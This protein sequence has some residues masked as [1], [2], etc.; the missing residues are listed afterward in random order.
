MEDEKTKAVA[1]FFLK[2]CVCLTIHESKDFKRKYYGHKCLW[3]KE[4]FFIIGGG[5]GG[6]DVCVE[7]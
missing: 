1:F 2:L 7:L 5:W 6:G 4:C 3:R